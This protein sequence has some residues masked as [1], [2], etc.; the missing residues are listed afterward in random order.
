MYLVEV[1]GVEGTGA[2]SNAKCHAKV[3]DL[4]EPTAPTPSIIGEYYSA[5]NSTM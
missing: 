5:F 4:F 3:F 2:A 1:L